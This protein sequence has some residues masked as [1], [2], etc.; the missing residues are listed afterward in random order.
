MPVRSG[1]CRPSEDGT[2]GY[3]RFLVFSARSL[4][5]GKV[6]FG[7]M[8]LLPLRSAHKASWT[9]ACFRR[10]HLDIDKES[11]GWKEEEEARME[12][13]PTGQTHMPRHRSN[14]YR[15][16][17]LIKGWEAELM[18]EARIA[19]PTTDAVRADQDVVDDDLMRMADAA[20]R[21]ATRRRKRGDEQ[22]AAIAW[23]TAKRDETGLT[24]LAKMLDADAANLGKV[25][26]GKRKPSKALLAKIAAVRSQST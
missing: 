23:L 22:T 7:S 13:Q 11:D 18:R 20:E 26:E 2:N 6:R 10:Y 1:Q 16:I 24:A 8:E 3:G 15:M 19:M 4:M 12:D 25:I 9:A 17:V 5:E 14:R 21:I